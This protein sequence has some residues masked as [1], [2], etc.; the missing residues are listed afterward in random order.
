[1]ELPTDIGDSLQ[2]KPDYEEMVAACNL[3]ESIDSKLDYRQT[4]TDPEVEIENKEEGP[5]NEQETHL[6]NTFSVT[7]EGLVVALHIP[8]KRGSKPFLITVVVTVITIISVILFFSFL[9]GLIAGIVS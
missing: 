8:F 1:M 9:I 7:K 6:K 3:Y 5:E 4:A 2:E